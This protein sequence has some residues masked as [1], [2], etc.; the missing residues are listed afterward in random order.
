MLTGNET[1]RVME[2]ALDFLKGERSVFF[3]EEKFKYIRIFWLR[4]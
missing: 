1:T 2:V 3:F 4:R